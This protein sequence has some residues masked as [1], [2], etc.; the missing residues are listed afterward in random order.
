MI[1]KPDTA[2]NIIR[3][4]ILNLH[5]ENLQFEKGELT[6]QALLATDDNVAKY[7]EKIKEINQEIEQINKQIENLI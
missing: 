4:K 6:K 2:E 5:K 7:Q 3:E 1:K